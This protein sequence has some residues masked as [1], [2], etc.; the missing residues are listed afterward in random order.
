MI[1]LYEFSILQGVKPVNFESIYSLH[2]T[3]KS[4]AHIDLRSFNHVDIRRVA[5][6]SLKPTGDVDATGSAVSSNAPSFG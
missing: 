6:K 4:K 2:A 5:C 1:V 3:S